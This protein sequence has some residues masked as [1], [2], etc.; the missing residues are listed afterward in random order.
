MRQVA[1]YGVT[2]PCIAPTPYHI[3]YCIVNEDFLKCPPASAHQYRKSWA[4]GP[5]LPRS[6]HCRPCGHRRAHLLRCPGRSWFSLRV[7]QNL[8]RNV[9]RDTEA[10]SFL[11]SSSCGIDRF[12][13][14]SLPMRR[15]SSPSRSSVDTLLRSGS[16][17]VKREE[18]TTKAGRKAYP[19][20]EQL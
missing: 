10:Q 4:S 13:H 12:S 6:C 2:H 3:G 14:H 19:P 9:V 18:E 11:R 15:R 1:F 17:E 7:D 16:V 5:K 8:F 20:W